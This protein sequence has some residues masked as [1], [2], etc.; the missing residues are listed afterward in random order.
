[1][2]ISTDYNFDK[3]I[4]LLPDKLP[5]NRCRANVSGVDIELCKR[6]SRDLKGNRIDKE[7]NLVYKIDK[8]GK[9][10]VNRTTAYA[11]QCESIVLGWTKQFFRKNQQL[12]LSKNCQKYPELYEELKNAIKIIAPDFI[13]D[14]ITI[15]HNL[16]CKRHIDGRNVGDSIIVGLG[17]YEGGELKVEDKIYDINQKPLKFNGSK[18]YHETLDFK[19]DRWSII[20]FRKLK[21]VNL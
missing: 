10:N 1:M 16:K 2:E 4:N 14:S 21:N 15:N 20:W 6:N 5:F 8:N 12:K 11:N 17:N 3:I 19:G 13:S 9:K 7:G 18:L